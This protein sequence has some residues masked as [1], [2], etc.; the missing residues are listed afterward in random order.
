MTFDGKAFGKEVVDVVKTYVARHVEPLEELIAELEKR[1]AELEGRGVRY[2]GV[3]QRATQYRRGAV[4]THGGGLWVAL[5][6]VDG[7]VPGSDPTAWQL[8]VKGGK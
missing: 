5:R 3:F 6:G 7:E 1:I 4:V 2:E 8:A